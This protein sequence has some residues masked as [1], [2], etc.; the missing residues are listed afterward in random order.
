M[1]YEFYN[2]NPQEK[3]VGDCTVRALSKVLDLDWDTVYW[4]ICAQGSLCAD[5]PSSDD[6][7]GAYLH[8][9]GFKRKLISNESFRNY[10]VQDFC[11]DNPDG[12][13]VLATGSHVVAVKNGV[14]F[15]AG[16]SGRESPI[17]YW[18]KVE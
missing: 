2:P 17:Y 14:Y 11:N 3:L 18:E 7:W 4:D 6:V 10:T 5:M 13:F 8:K 12:V 1:A 15:D 9:K 16:D